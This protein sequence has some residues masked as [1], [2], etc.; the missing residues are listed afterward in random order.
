[1]ADRAADLAWSKQ[2]LTILALVPYTV[3]LTQHVSPH[4]I[5]RHVR[6]NEQSAGRYCRIK[7][8]RITLMP[9][10]HVTVR[11]RTWL[12]EMHPHFSNWKYLAKNG[13][14]WKDWL[15]GWRLIVISQTV[16]ASVS[17]SMNELQQLHTHTCWTDPRA[18]LTVSIYPF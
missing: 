12:S 8:W 1:M 9:L 18:G 15:T 10:L 2:S 13:F 16:S 6:D 17:H 3:H 4:I 5:E 7:V 11:N 14:V